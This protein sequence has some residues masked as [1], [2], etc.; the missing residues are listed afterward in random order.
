MVDDSVISCVEVLTLHNAGQNR[1]AFGKHAPAPAGGEVADTLVFLSV[2]GID[3]GF[4]RVGARHGR[5]VIRHIGRFGH[6]LVQSVPHVE[7][8]VVDGLRAHSCPD[9]DGDGVTEAYPRAGRLHV[10]RRFFLH[11]WERALGVLGLVACHVLAEPGHRQ[12]VLPVAYQAGVAAGGPCGTVDIAPQRDAG[13]VA[14]LPH[15]WNLL[16]VALQL[17]VVVVG[18]DVILRAVHRHLQVRLQL[19]HGRLERVDVAVGQVVR[20]AA[21][22][23]NRSTGVSDGFHQSDELGAVP[24]E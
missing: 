24:L 7:L 1:S 10:D 16:F 22:G 21:V 4:Q 11:A 5:F 13:T 19:V 23:V 8:H 6:R 12:T 3:D 20:L 15:I 17:V 14:R 18:A 2:G 9:G